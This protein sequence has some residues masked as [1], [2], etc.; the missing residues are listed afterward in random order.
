MPRTGADRRSS[1]QKVTAASPRQNAGES[2]RRRCHLIQQLRIYEIFERNKAAFHARFEEHAIRIMR[3][4][5]FDI[6]AM[7]ESALPNG[8]RFVYILNW[9]D[10][11]TKETAWRDFLA[12][13][14]WV[15]IKRTT[16]AEHGDLVGDVE[17]HVLAPTSYSPAAIVRGG[18]R[19]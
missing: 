3:R 6:V 8:P 16:K 17:D 9:P 10:V 19:A 11:A 2:L 12:D 7:W 15:E 5:G 1:S 13:R 4:Y 18:R 14:E